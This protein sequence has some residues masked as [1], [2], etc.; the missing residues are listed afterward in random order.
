MAFVRE[1]ISTEEDKKI[2]DSLELKSSASNPK[3]EPITAWLGLSRWVIDRQRKIIM[4]ELGGGSFEK[5]VY[6]QLI[7]PEGRVE[8]AAYTSGKTVIPPA[9]NLHNNKSYVAIFQVD[10]VAIPPQLQSRRKEILDM[11][12]ETLAV[13]KGVDRLDGVFAVEVT[14]NP[15]INQE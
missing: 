1:V 10:W 9:A 14:F 6:F 2:Y 12:K 3:A 4:C 8:F 13:E 15:Q 5:P 7:F 11:I